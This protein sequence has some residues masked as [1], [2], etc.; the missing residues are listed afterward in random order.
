MIIRMKVNFLITQL[1]LRSLFVCLGLLLFSPYSFGQ[2]PDSVI[3]P[4]S[5]KYINCSPIRVLL[6]GKN[7]REEWSTPVKMPVFNLKKEKGGFTIKE[8]GGGQQTKSLRLLDKDGQEWVLRSTD[9]DVAGAL[10]AT[11]NNKFVSS[12]VKNVVQDM[13]S[14]SH[15]YGSLTVP[16]L[17]KAAGVIVARPKLFFVPD[18]PAFGEYRHIFANTVCFLE[19]REPTPDQ[20]E[21]EDTEDVMEKVL[22]KNDHQLLQQIVLR[23]RLLDMLI[24]DWDRHQD[25]WKW[26]TQK[27]DGTT[28]YYPVP[29]DRDFAYFKSNG[30]IVLF[31]SMTVVPH[32][33]SFTNDGSALKRLSNKTWEMDGQW[34]NQLDE[35]DWK[36]AII[37]FQNKLTDSVI[38]TAIRKIPR[39]IYA[40]SG[41]KLQEKLKGRRNGL[42]EHAMDYYRFLATNPYVVGS[43]EQEFFAVTKEGNDITITASRNGSKDK[44]DV[45]YKRTFTPKDT[46]KIY[47]L[48][49][50]GNDH[51]DIDENVSSSIKLQLEGGN[52]DDVYNVRGKI[53]TTIEDDNSKNKTGLVA[54]SRKKP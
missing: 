10:A 43:E 16:D 20:S 30:L 32:M 19:D 35:Q 21:T 53:K 54:S 18:D 24:A 45:I 26:G 47:I 3:V 17:A 9:K 7:Y 37:Q 25:Q 29:K 4:A 42:L 39:E 52:G 46:K 34:L 33:R 15:P 36:N 48:G 38:E 44:K 6:A 28:Y 49:L 41:K 13:I 50:D 23:A 31:A 27:R 8:L 12:L 40:I 1:L 51:F 2:F 11:L 14:A 22:E 5:M